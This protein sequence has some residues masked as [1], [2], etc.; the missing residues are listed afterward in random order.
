[1]A[2]V[3][4]KQIYKIELD[5]SLVEYEVRTKARC[6][7]LR[8]TVTA[9]GD[10]VVTVPS[11]FPLTQLEEVIAGKSHWIIKQIQKAKDRCDF[12]TAR[13]LV[14]GESLPCLGINY[15]L[16]IQENNLDKISVWLANNNTLTVSVPAFLTGDARKQEIIKLLELWYARQARNIFPD[17]VAEINRNFG[18]VYNRITIR[19]QQTRWGSC[20]NLNNLNF[21]WRL[22]LAPPEILDYVIIHELAHL[23]ELNHS[24]EFWRLVE[25]RCPYFREAKKWLR[26]NGHT[27]TI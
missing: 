20:S 11:N 18:F 17:R 25:S 23:R 5:N 6:K 8:F 15:G 12:H 22:L 9:K 2:K 3:N 13:E 24:G 19:S 1:M 21:N 16:G 14:T 26:D 10:L 7:N 27:L 4:Q